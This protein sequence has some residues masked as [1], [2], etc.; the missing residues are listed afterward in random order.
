ME[1]FSDCPD[2][3]LVTPPRNGQNLEKREVTYDYLTGTLPFQLRKDFEKSFPFVGELLREGKGI[4]GYTNSYFYDSG[5]VIAYSPRRPELKT[6]FS[7]PGQTISFFGHFLKIDSE[8]LVEA[9]SSR[10]AIFTRLDLALDEKEEILCLDTI[11]DKLRK[12][13]VSSRLRSWREYTGTLPLSQ[14]RS[15]GIQDQRKI[16]RTIYLGDLK[17]GN[18]VF[19]I[20]DK[21]SEQGLSEKDHWIRVE[22]QLRREVAE[23]Y[24]QPYIKEKNEKGLLQKVRIY[25]ERNPKKIFMYYLRF[26]E[27]DN[28][29]KKR[30]STCL[31]WEKFLE[32]DGK[33][34]IGLSKYQGT[35]EDLYSWYE[36]SISGLG[37][38]LQKADPEKFDEIRNKTGEKLYNQNKRY[39]TLYANHRNRNQ[40]PN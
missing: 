7:F 14:I 31:W 23:Q 1:I 34:K 13:H 19:R 9:M 37:Y 10:G 38:L 16:G 26:L 36:N 28:S 3:G 12:G 8:T 15:Q 21:A 18:V 29:E 24:L 33:E 6:Y 11:Y 22:L 4:H 39:K 40:E 30:C 35:L 5:T 20:Y 17:T 25:K 2:G 32:T 27:M